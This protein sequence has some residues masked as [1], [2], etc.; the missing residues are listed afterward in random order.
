[1]KKH[2]SV[3]YVLAAVIAALVV[4]CTATGASAAFPAWMRSW[5]WPIFAR[6]ALSTSLFV[7]VM[8]A[9]AVP[10]G[11]GLMKAIMPVRG[12]LSIIACILTLGHN[13]SYGMTYFR[14]LFVSPSRLPANQLAA[15]VCSLV[16]LCIMLPLFITSFKCVRKKMKGSSWK[17]LQRLAYG[18]YALI[19]IHVLLLALPAARK[20]N[21]T[22]LMTVV[23]YSVVFLTYGAMRAR[24]A[25]RNHS[26]ALRRVPTLASI[27]VLALVL[28]TASGSVLTST[29]A[30]EEQ[31]AARQ[32]TSDSTLPAET[33]TVSAPD[34]ET[35][36]EAEEAEEADTADEQD[37]ASAPEEA[38]AAA[39]ET[40]A[41]AETPENAQAAAAPAEEP[42]PAET[43]PA[44]EEK[45]AEPAVVYQ[46]K[47]GTFSGTASGFEGPITVSVTIEND[48]IINIVV[49]SASEDEPYWSD[50]KTIISRILSA[51]STNVNTVSGATFSSGGIR[52]AVKA[53]LNSAKN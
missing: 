27:C 41:P 53:A 10:N 12:E 50:G 20:G 30:D 38:E 39:E 9:N 2:A 8:Y 14:L 16:M 5:V 25:L 47:N 23:M 51:Q 19:Y 24:K 34:G 26:A 18:F 43:Q 33:E 46:Y 52:D 17:K 11:S 21:V 37:A 49:T 28:V 6:S 1:M 36:D 3:C 48:R 40:E 31:T 22:Y 35:A 29:H 13:V 4:V 15:A 45:P 7:A 32:E 44:E 42:A